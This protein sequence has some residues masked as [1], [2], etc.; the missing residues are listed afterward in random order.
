MLGLTV[1]A[2]QGL[3][4]SVAPHLSGLE[5]AEGG[6]ETPL[7]WFGVKWE[8]NASTFR[9]IVDTPGGTSGVLLLP[10][11][12]ETTVDGIKAELG[13]EGNLVTLK[14]GVHTVVVHVKT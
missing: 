2:P 13:A 6:F 12:G 11:R 8:S 3:A 1:T 4:W 14:G 10:V 9:V 7:G 5:A